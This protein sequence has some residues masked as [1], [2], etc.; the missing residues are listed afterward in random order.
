MKQIDP[1]LQD[2]CERVQKKIEER[3]KIEKIG[4]AP[5]FM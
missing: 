5:H 1:E 2:I 4:S 3:Q